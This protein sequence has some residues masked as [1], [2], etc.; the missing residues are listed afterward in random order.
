MPFSTANTL[1][2]DRH[3]RNLLIR[4][5]ACSDINSHMRN[6]ACCVTLLA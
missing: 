5:H 2:G 3:V 1:N 6:L 4:C